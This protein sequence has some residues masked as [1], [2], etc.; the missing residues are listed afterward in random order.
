MGGA[1]AATLFYLLRVPYARNVEFADAPILP[2]EADVGMVF[3]AEVLT[4]RVFAAVR[5]LLG[6]FLPNP[7]GLTPIVLTSCLS[8]GVF[9]AAMTALARSAGRFPIE[10][11]TLWCGATLGGYTGMFFG[12]VETTQVE[13]AAMAVY[14]AAAA[15]AVRHS[16]D[17]QHTRWLVVALVALSIALQAH[18]A[19]ILLLPSAIVLLAPQLARPKPSFGDTA[20]R[21]LLWRNVGLAAVLVVLPYLLAVV[22]P[23][24]AQSE[25]GNMLGGGDGIMFVPWRVDPAHPP[26]RY[27]YY[28][29][30]SPMHLADLAST[31]LVAAP[32]ALPLCVWAG[33]RLVRSR[34]R[35]SDRDRR[36]LLLLA[37]AA[38]PC[39]VVPLAW[40]HDLGMW[41]DWNL[42]TCYLFPLNLLAWSLLVAT[43][44]LRE[45]A[46]SRGGTV[47]RLVAIQVALALGLLLQLW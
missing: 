25:F 15:R 27:V 20:P 43:P 39:L 10:R 47:A 16:A 44:R 3:A 21:R 14:F 12:Y 4:Y 18:A 26:S 32:L 40:N 8:G 2:N 9:V 42:A 38:G 6:L 5:S 46:C 35:L 7:G 29:L 31:F 11:W 36:W 45:P 19:G 34:T 41:G 13:L 24:Y 23:F 28:A 30:F 37:A 1:V 33:W 17:D 22:L